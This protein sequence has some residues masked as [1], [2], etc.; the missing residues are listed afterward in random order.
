MPVDGEKLQ[1]LVSREL[2]AESTRSQHQLQFNSLGNRERPARAAQTLILDCTHQTPEF[3]PPKCEE[4]TKTQVRDTKSTGILRPC[5]KCSS[6]CL[7]D[8]TAPVKSFQYSAVTHTELPRRL[9]DHTTVKR[10][11][12]E[13][14]IKGSCAVTSSTISSS[15]PPASSSSSPP[16]YPLRRQSGGSSGPS[17]NGDA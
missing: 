3:T 4:R 9:G 1:K 13:D 16:S 15:T 17:S 6:G 11:N 5:K 10:R 12:T 8:R 2:H 7:S 14:I